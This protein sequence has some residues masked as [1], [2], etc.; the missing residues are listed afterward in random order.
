MRKIQKILIGV[1]AAGVLLTGIG[2]G[3]AF[4]EYSTLTYGGQK[5]IGEEHL[6]TKTL[7]YKLEDFKE[8]V[9]L[10]EGLDYHASHVTE[11]MEDATVPKNEIQF[12]VT[13]NEKRVRPYLWSNESESFESTEEDPMRIGLG[14]EYER[15]EFAEF[16]EVRD[17]VLNELKQNTISSYEIIYVTD[18]LVKAHPET[19]AVIRE[20]K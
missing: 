7:T 6:A 12:Q 3:V 18:V 1:F 14:I 11:L 20:V 15:N 17:I 9:I 19:M 16:M 13:Y 2:T 10:L 4:V 8:E 5:I